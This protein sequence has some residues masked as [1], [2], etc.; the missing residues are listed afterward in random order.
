MENEQTQ[1][2]QNLISVLNFPEDPKNI[3]QVYTLQNTTSIP[4][5]ITYHFAMEVAPRGGGGGE[6][7]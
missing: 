7:N 2:Y 3:N 6:Q 1:K 4:K 5:L